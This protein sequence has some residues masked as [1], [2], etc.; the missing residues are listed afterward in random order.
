MPPTALTLFVVLFALSAIL[1]LRPAY[2]PSLGQGALNA[3]L[4]SA[5]LY[6][7]ISLLAR[8]TAVARAV[9]ALVALAGGV[10]AL[11]F[12]SQFAYHNYPDTPALIERLGNQTTF[13][14]PIWLMYLH[15]NG[16]A[17]LLEVLLPLAAALFVSSRRSLVIRV[18]CAFVIVVMLYAV[19]LTFSRGAW[20]GLGAAAVLAAALALA[21]RLPRGLATAAI[22]V[23]VALVAGGVVFVLAGGIERLPFLQSTF[24]AAESRL[25]LYRN[26]LYLA[27][28]Y[29]YTGIGLGDTFAMVYSRYS[30]LIFVPFLTYAHNL[31]LAVWLGQGLLGLVALAGIVI[32]FY[33]LVARVT[34][35]AAPDALFHGAWLGVTATLVHG[36]T[37]SRQYIES[38]WA[39]PALFIA[40]ALAAALGRLALREQPFERPRLAARLAVPVVIGAAAVVAALALNVPLRALWATNQGAVDETRAELTP[41]LDDTQRAELQES[42]IRH[43]QA[44]LALDPGQ[45]NASRRLGNLYVALERY[46]EAVPL[47]EKAAAAEPDYPGAVKGLGLAYVWVGRTDEAAQTLARLDNRRDIINELYTWSTFQGEQNR[48]DLAAYARETADRLDGL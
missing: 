31:F 12:I 45:P 48:P 15:P 16:V 43:Y 7:A 41:G 13:L 42:A 1:G 24:A 38:P 27:S 10:F 26:A 19:F 6:L 40:L 9:G 47:L 28:D 8:T 18:L 5:F 25:T 37:D 36:L 14:P 46:D 23:I 35:R 21:S 30:L 11:Y 44:A 32:T 20:I 39:M 4:G 22:V 3:V 34:R 2:D 33:A 17:T 29:A